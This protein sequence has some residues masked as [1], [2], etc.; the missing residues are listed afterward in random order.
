MKFFLPIILA[1]VLAGCG[2]VA[3]G[4]LY[5]QAASSI[6][7]SSDESIIVVYR[8]SRV[9][10]SAAGMNLVVNDRNE[11]PLQPLGFRSLSVMPGKITIH[12]DTSAI[13]RVSTITAEPGKRYFF[14]TKFSNYVMTGAWDLVEVE[15]AVAERELS[16]LRNSGPAPDK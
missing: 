2:S 8:P 7:V 1:A 5:S 11:G 14:R 15:P 3:Q 4:P 9:T 16:E 6:G 12:T 13:D 10:G